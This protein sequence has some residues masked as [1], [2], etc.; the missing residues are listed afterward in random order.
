MRDRIWLTHTLCTWVSGMGTMWYSWIPSASRTRLI[1]SYRSPAVKGFSP[2]W[3]YCAEPIPTMIS[4]FVSRI[5]RTIARWP[6][7]NGWER[8]MNRALP[9]LIPPPPR[10]V[11]DRRGPLVG[12]HLRDEG[13]ELADQPGLLRA[14]KEVVQDLAQRVDGHDL[15]LP[16]VLVLQEDI[17]H[18]R[19]RDDYLYDPHLRG[20]FDLR[21]HASNGQNLPADTQGAGHRDALVHGDLLEGADDRR[22]DGDRRAVPFRAL[23]RSDELDVDVVVRDVLARIL[24]DQ[25]GDVLD[26]FLRDLPEASGR[27][28]PT[29]LLRLRGGRLCR[30]RQDDAAEFRDGVVPDE[31]GGPVHHPDDMSFRDEGLVLLSAL[32]HPVRDLLFEGACDPLRVQDVLR[33]DE[34][35][36]LF[37]R[38]VPRD[39]DQASELTQSEGQLPSTPG[40]PLRPP[41]AL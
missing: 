36:A 28:D 17:P 9:P 21:R 19:P 18:V 39:P 35:R 40:A 29:A 13:R 8:P 12:A 41:P 38:D 22:G 2:V 7:W 16:Y 5:F 10:S 24:L 1:I 31:D 25:G 4:A 14:H 32:D 33:K 11:G 20:G 15:D 26:G 34:G 3:L 30:A 6:L 37:L 27:D 23:T